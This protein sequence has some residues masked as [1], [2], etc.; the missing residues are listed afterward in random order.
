MLEIESLEPNKMNVKRITIIQII[1]TIILSISF[2]FIFDYKV[3]LGIILGSGTGYL[4]FYLLNNK[5]SNLSDDEIP[6]MGKI[7][8]S[9]RNF[10]YLVLI[11]ILII[12][13]LLPQIFNIIAVCFSVLINKI[14]IYIDLVINKK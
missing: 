2:F 4:N 7:I 10:R 12:S 3:S 5:I 14:S 8:K 13:G 11:L 9:N 1:I 6:N